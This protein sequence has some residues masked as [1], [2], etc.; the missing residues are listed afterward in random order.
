[1]LLSEN[2]LLLVNIDLL[3]CES[4]AH[5]VHRDGSPGA[6][7]PPHCGGWRVFLTANMGLHTD[8]QEK[9]RKTPAAETM[10]VWQILAGCYHYFS[11]SQMSLT[12]P[13]SSSL[14]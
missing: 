4:A 6:S 11:V 8:R 1:M 3:I 13:S 7:F 10:D 14:D 5:I 9:N 12:C 2:V